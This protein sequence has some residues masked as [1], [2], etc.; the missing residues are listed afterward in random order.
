MAC[1]NCRDECPHP[2]GFGQ[3]GDDDSMHTSNGFH[4]PSN[5]FHIESADGPPPLAKTSVEDWLLLEASAP[6]SSAM[7]YFHEPSAF[8]FQQPPAPQELA[9]A[10]PQQEHH[11][12]QFGLGDNTQQYFEQDQPDQPPVQFAPQQQ[13]QEPQHQPQEQQEQQQEQQRDQPQQPQPQEQQQKQSA[14]AKR[15][16]CASHAPPSP[17]LTPAPQLAQEQQPKQLDTTDDAAIADLLSC[18][19]LLDPEAVAADARTLASQPPLLPL[20]MPQSQAAVWERSVQR[21]A[22]ALQV[23]L[24]AHV[25]VAP[26]VG[27]HNMWVDKADVNDSVDCLRMRC[28]SSALHMQGRPPQPPATRPAAEALPRLP[29]Q[30]DSFAPWMPPPRANGTDPGAG[31]VLQG[32]GPY[33]SRAPSAAA[34]AKVP[35]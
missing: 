5:G 19:W 11:R 30:E 1:P 8:D 34:P 6:L 20:H 15:S 33:F 18:D 3:L 4:P 7:D 13:Q 23:H 22:A 24:F 25:T 31:P 27:L 10:L 12:Q 32:G 17:A 26:A 28:A 2:V 35:A 21:A 14:K 16:A 29:I 9:P